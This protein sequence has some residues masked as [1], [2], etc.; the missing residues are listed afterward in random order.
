MK[1]LITGGAGFIGSHLAQALCARGASVIVLDDLS[2]GSLENLA[3]SQNCHQLDF[4]H[5]DVG[6]DAL[7]SKIMPGCDWVFHQAAIASV[8]ATIEQPVKSNAV[9][10]EA[11]VKLLAHARDAGVKRFL[12]AS[13]AAIY[14][15]GPEPVKHESLPVLPLSPYGLQKYASERY[16][17]HFHR[18]YGL[19]TVSLRYFNVFG[20]RQSFTSAYSGVIAR[21]CT[22]MLNGETPTL[23]GDGKQSRD[24][25]AIDNVVQANLLAAEAPAE[26]VAGRFFN[27][28]TGH[29]ISLL[30]LIAEINR[31]TGQHIMPQHAP[32]RLG[33]I[34]HSLADITA[35]R[36]ALHFEPSTSWQEGLA[37]TLAFYAS[38]QHRP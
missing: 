9:N 22:A 5:G 27:C 2:S 20:P 29:A 25:I 24:F 30:D 31:Q 32:A 10:L 37:Q 6:D 16:A 7:L 8:P 3:W 35:I 13:S 36:Q 18:Y 26:Q 15:D 33:D 23:F 19:P 1:A 14:G 11:T 4:I 21:F 28:A 12:F 34:Q 38:G 17:Q